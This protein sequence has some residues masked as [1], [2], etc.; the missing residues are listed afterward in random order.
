MIYLSPKG[1]KNSNELDKVGSWI[2]NHLDKE[3]TTL[4]VGDFNFT[5]AKWIADSFT[6]GSQCSS[7]FIEIIKTCNFTQ[8]I[9]NPTRG[10]SILDLVF[11][12]SEQ[13]VHSILVGPPLNNMCDHNSISMAVILKNIK[14][15]LDKKQFLDFRK[16]D[17]L[18]INNIFAGI[19]WKELFANKTD[20][21][22]CY[23]K[24]CTIVKDVIE[25]HVPYQKS[26]RKNKNPAHIRKMAQDRSKFWYKRNEPYIRPIYERISRDYNRELNK[27]VKNKEKRFINKNPTNLF[28]LIRYKA[29]PKNLKIPALNNNGSLIIRDE[30]KATFFLDMFSEIYNSESTA[31]MFLNPKI[32][33]S[34]NINTFFFTEFYI[35]ESLKKLPN[36]FNKCPD[37]I[38]FYFLKQCALTLASPIAHML[39][40]SFYSG[41]LPSRWK[42]AIVR[43]LYKNKGKLDDPK[44]YRPISI[45]G[46]I[47]KIAEKHMFQSISPYIEK[48][49]SASQ[50]GFRIGKSTISCLLE[51]F[52]D[53]TLAIDEGKSIDI[54]FFDIHKAFD[55]VDHQ[56]LL[57]KLYNIGLPIH[58]VNWIKNFISNRVL[59]INVNETF[60]Q[61]SQL[62]NKGVPQGTTLAPI[63]FNIFVSD[64]LDQWDN[65]KIIIKSFADDFMAYTIFDETC[66]NNTYILQ[67]FIEHFRH[68]CYYNGLKISNIDK[69]FVLHL[70][71]KNKNFQYKFNDISIHKVEESIRY[72]GLN[73]T[74]DLKWSRHISIISKKAYGLWYSFFKAIKVTDTKTLCKIYTTYVR[75]LLEYGSEIFN[76]NLKKNIRALELV[77]K[78]ITRAIIYRRYKEYMPYEQR[79]KILELDTLSNRRHIKDIYTFFKILNNDLVLEDKFKPKLKSLQLKSNTYYIPYAK[80]NCRFNSFFPR[81]TRAVNKLSNHLNSASSLSQVR[82][83]L[84]TLDLDNLL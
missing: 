59:T 82:T 52:E 23:N 65:D 9:T 4:I 74:P 31:D 80:L 39:R 73:I 44:N 51:C 61:P 63:L 58:V 22:Y 30:D 66:N 57:S 2:Y 11:V 69:L 1:S 3:I 83:I 7:D 50:H 68:W 45:T 25:K 12:N 5:E 40:T 14:N 72:L 55:T 38:P 20:I 71:K 84:S 41:N 79:L 56:R 19:N 37:G 48:C 60:T 70:G 8:H 46:S 67:K 10:N 34:V 81:T 29:K 33:D 15:K 64:L 26:P 27:Y 77:Q 18:S 28:K 13:A 42:N 53:W 54:I 78:R 32:V 16:A 49:L 43:P 36:K 62:I 24:F 21:N 35:Y 76:S 47:I 17:Y 75:P 6:T